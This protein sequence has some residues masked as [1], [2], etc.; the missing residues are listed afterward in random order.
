MD[1][2]HNSEYSWTIEYVERQNIVKVVVENAFSANGHTKMIEDVVSQKFWNPGM[3]LLI[4]DRKVEF[5]KTD[6][7]LVKRVSE[8]FELLEKNSVKGKLRF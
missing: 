6:I 1:E 8:G 2:T 3:N 7:E 5:K 4:D